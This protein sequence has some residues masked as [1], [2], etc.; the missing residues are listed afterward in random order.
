MTALLLATLTWA[1]S[2]YINGVRA[3]VLPDATLRNVTV[4]LDADGNV[5][6]DAPQYRVETIPDPVPAASTASPTASGVTAGS[7]WLVTEDHATTGQLLDISVNSARVYR[8]QSGQGPIVLDLG[9]YLRRGT[10]EVR[11]EPIANGTLGGGSFDVYVGRGVMDN[12]T[13]RIDQP[14]VHYARSPSDPV[15]PRVYAITVP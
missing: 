10:N 6:I 4:R 11:V 3:D 13:I 2:V 15:G 12:G 14:L 9:P 5:W 7:W 1:G 8:V